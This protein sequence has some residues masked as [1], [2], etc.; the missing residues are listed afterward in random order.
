MRSS[1]PPELWV[2]IECTRS[3]IRDRVIDQVVRTGHEHRIDDL[4]RL[5]ALGVNTVRYPLLWDRVEDPLGRRDWRWSDRRMHRLQALAIRP[6][7]GLLH[8]GGG[9]LRN[10]LLDPEF[11]ERFAAYAGDV[12]RRYPWVDAYLPVNEPLTTARFAG[13]YGVWHPH[14]TDLETF[15]RLLLAQCRAV[16]LATREIRRVRPDAEILQSE[17]VGRV[18]A[19][20]RLR[21]QAEYENERRWLTF[22]LLTGTL[23]RDRPMWTVLR[24]A[25]ISAGELQWFLD[26]TPEVDA[27]AV[28]HYVT[29]D[30]FLDPRVQ[31]YPR[32][33]RSGNGREEYAN[34]ESVRA[35]TPY[36]G[37][38]GAVADTHRRY[39]RP[40]VLG[41]VHVSGN[42]EEQLRWLAEVWQLANRPPAGARVRAMNVWSAFGAYD[43]NTLL[44]RDD[45][46][47]ESGVFD[48]RSGTPRPTALADMVRALANAEPYDH[49]SLDGLGWWRRSDRVRY[50]CRRRS[51]Q[52]EPAG[53]EARPIAVEPGALAALAC[54]L[55]RSRGL[56]HEV[57]AG[58]TPTDGWASVRV[59]GPEEEVPLVRRAAPHRPSLTVRAAFAP[60]T[61]PRRI[62]LA[63]AI[64]RGLDLLVDGVTG[65]VCADHL[66]DAC[67]EA[68]CVWIEL[69]QDEV[70]ATPGLAAAR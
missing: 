61:G 33:A 39:G 49:P 53:R 69:E 65:R 41:E 42:R 21:Y 67:A 70:W 48:V 10:G 66:D 4:D 36:A 64:H 7:V 20:E 50:P 1:L 52:P 32:W 5:A 19:A 55:L 16:V 26:E 25:G 3:R 54:S 44:T 63:A 68:S 37:F 45:G 23:D 62:A 30:R 34:V 6:V 9:P 13:L 31:A 58:P 46:W 57:A 60:T 40:I 8:H 17:D 15:A 51:P 29:S 27:L 12:A 47:Y 56:A 38:E 35:D 14:A 11:P 24:D 43:W 28:D 59:L 18:T 2:G 22:D